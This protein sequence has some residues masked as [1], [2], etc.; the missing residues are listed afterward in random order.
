MTCAE[1]DEILARDYLD[2]RDLMNLLG[3]SYNASAAL[4]RQIKRK[5]DRLH[6]QGKIHIQDYIDYYGLNVERYK[7]GKDAITGGE[8]K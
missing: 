5:N 6:I 4:I 7:S 2:I 8:S 1:R 3:L